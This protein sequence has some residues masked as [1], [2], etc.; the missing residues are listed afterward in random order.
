MRRC[1][2][3][4]QCPRC[5]PCEK[6]LKGRAKQGPCRTASGSTPRA[7]SRANSFKNEGLQRA[8]P[9]RRR[10]PRTV[11]PTSGSRETRRSPA[12]VQRLHTQAA[13]GP[14][15]RRLAPLD[16]TGRGIGKC[17]FAPIRGGGC[18]PLRWR[19]GLPSAASLA[20][21]R[22]VNESAR[23][24]SPA[25]RSGDSLIPR[26]TTGKTTGSGERDR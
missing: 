25:G 13:V 23:R 5:A 10:S 4:A 15:R 20:R 9:R 26:E 7:S 1:Q 19:Q 2:R 16:V 6:C 14:N 8:K 17:A 3:M 21:Q 24:C 12:V 11:R 22:V 18:H